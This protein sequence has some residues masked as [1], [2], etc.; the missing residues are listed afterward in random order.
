MTAPATS[1]SQVPWWLPIVYT[2]FGALLAFFFTRFQAWLEKRAASKS[3]IKAVRAELVAINQHLQGTL[4]DTTQSKEEFDRGD[5]HLL[6]LATAFQRVIYDSQIGKLK[7]VADPLVIEIVQFYDKL[8]NLE[9]VK[10]HFT[11]VS[12]ELSG[13]PTNPTEDQRVIPLVGKYYSALNEI[14]KRINE[15]LPIIAGLIAKL[16]R[17]D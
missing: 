7:T 15:L 13:L 14:I 4:K 2:T 5:R 3:F 11:A 17:I 1:S 8:A 9:R 16:Q 6:H 10:S 12:F